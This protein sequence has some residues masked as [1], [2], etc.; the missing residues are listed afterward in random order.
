MINFTQY[1]KPRSKAGHQKIGE[2][3][4]CSTPRKS[5]VKGERF[6]RSEVKQEC[7]IASSQRAE[8]TFWDVSL[9]HGFILV[10]L[11]HF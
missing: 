10:P 7:T 5:L 8:P 2:Y 9:R 4:K 3:S 1:R 11:F 6:M